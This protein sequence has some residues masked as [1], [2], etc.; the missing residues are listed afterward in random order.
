MN[1]RNNYHSQ[2]MHN[3]SYQQFPPALPP[4]PIQQ[5][6]TFHPMHGLHPI[7]QEQEVNHYYESHYNNYNNFNNY[8]NYNTYNNHNNN[9]WSSFRNIPTITALNFNTDMGLDNYH[10]DYNACARMDNQLIMDTMPQLPQLP[11]IPQIPPII[12]NAQL[13]E[14]NYSFCSEL[15]N[16]SNTTNEI[17][18]NNRMIDDSNNSLSSISHHSPSLK[19]DNNT[20]KTETDSP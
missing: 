7:Q 11:Q 19:S 4:P 10:I 6:D 18:Y 16:I 12:D 15:S 14:P 2:P 9:H 17:D 1:K 3:N 5:F 8:N 13:I 20:I